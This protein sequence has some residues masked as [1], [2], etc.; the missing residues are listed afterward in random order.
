MLLAGKDRDMKID[1]PP[2]AIIKPMAL[3]SGKQV[4]SIMIRPN[5]K[6]PVK[7]NLRTKGKSYTKDEELCINDSYI[8]V[9]NSDLLAGAL[10]KSIIGSGSKS[11]IFYT[12]L[13]DY[14]EQ[15]AADRM[16]RLARITPWFLSNHGFSIG[17]GD[18]TPGQGLIAAKEKL[19]LE[20]YQKCDKFIEEY[21]NGMLQTQPGCSPEE[22]LEAIILRE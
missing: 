9:H 20:G 10:D 11:S 6:C 8:V 7:M 16:W 22:T 19:L 15:A 21:A 2:P 12:L 14:G 5:K 13:R 18:V 3:W 1:I 17:I 4:V